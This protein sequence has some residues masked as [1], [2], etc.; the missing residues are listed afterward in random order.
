MHDQRGQA[1]GDRGLDGNRVRAVSVSYD[2]SCTWIRH[3]RRC[4]LIADL[5]GQISEMLRQLTAGPRMHRQELHCRREVACDEPIHC[6]RVRLRAAAI[7]VCA[8]ES[9]AAQRM[10]HHGDGRRGQVRSQRFPTR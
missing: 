3:A 10:S 7:G 2:P 5:T 1:L 8:S 6:V 9:S 4:Q